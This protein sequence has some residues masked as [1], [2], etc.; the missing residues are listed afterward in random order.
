MPSIGYHPGAPRVGPQVYYGQGS[1]GPIPPQVAG[2]G[3]QPQLISGFQPGFSPNFMMPYQLQRQGQ[4][5]QQM[6]VRRNGA[7]LQQQQVCY[8]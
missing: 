4:F 2:F 3:F 5:G 8:Q 6:S 7:H 1:P